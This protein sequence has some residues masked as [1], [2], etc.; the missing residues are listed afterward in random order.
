MRQQACLL[1]QPYSSHV[2]LRYWLYL[3]P[4]YSPTSRYPLLL[5]LHGMGER[6]DDLELIKK[7]G[8]PKE[9][10]AG[11]DFPFIV[12]SPQCP[13]ET[14][15]QYQTTA[16][17]ALL[18]DI[19][20]HYAVDPDRVYVTG[21]SMGGFGTWALAAAYPQRFAALLPICGGGEHHS[22]ALFKH[23]PVW[24]FHGDQDDAVP[25]RR[26][27]EMVEALQAVGGNVKF[28]VYEGVGHDSWTQTYA[29]PEIYDWLLQH[30]RTKLER[31]P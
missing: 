9:I 15:W 24:V 26:S 11:R 6:G 8:M 21:L 30:K 5:F 3:P 14:V 17:A 31:L 10:E 23:V 16:L 18:D 4:D 28:T 1:D 7:H 29:N 27:V 22:A 20:A 2:R 19:E 25:L 12:V 13:L